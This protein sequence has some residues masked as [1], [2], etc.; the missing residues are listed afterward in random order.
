MWP[1]EML[2]SCFHHELCDPGQ[3]TPLSG[4]L[5]PQSHS[6][7]RPGARHTQNRLCQPSLCS[8]PVCA[9]PGSTPAMRASPLCRGCF[10]QPP[11]RVSEAG[12]LLRVCAQPGSR[13]PAAGCQEL[14]VGVGDRVTW[15]RQKGSG[16]SETRHW[17]SPESTP[18]LGP[19]KLI[20]P[21]TSRRT[22]R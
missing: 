5:F 10:Y 7:P 16:V 18:S 2:R 11:P 13:R 12:A 4:P 22:W 6:G 9:S 3:V 17:R 8:R 21:Q 15:A 19:L 20:C 1:R 14:S